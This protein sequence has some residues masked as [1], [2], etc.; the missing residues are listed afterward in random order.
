DGGLVDLLVFVDVVGGAVAGH[1]AHVGAGGGWGA[2]VVLH[3]VVL[4]QGVGGPAVEG[5][6]GG[7]AGGV[8]VGGEGDGVVG[9][10]VPA[11]AG[12]EVADAAPG[13][14]V[15]GGGVQGDA[16]GAL[17][18]GPHLVVVAAVGAGL[19]RTEGR[20]GVGG[21][22]GAGQDRHGRGQ[23]GGHRGGAGTADQ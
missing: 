10:G 6:Q 23:H 12:D 9:A 3:D 2:V 14:G 1:L 21:A 7:A 5:D 17:A 4:D 16:G 8:E 20:R 18:G 15:A 19:A 13:G 22:G 11:D